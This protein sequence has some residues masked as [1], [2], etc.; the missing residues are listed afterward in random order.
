MNE[1]MYE[2]TNE[3]SNKRTSERTNDQTDKRTNK[4]TNNS[5]ALSPTRG[6]LK[7]RLN[8]DT[9]IHVPL[10]PLSVNAACQLH[11]WAYKETHPLD[12][13]EG[14]NKKPPGSRSHVM[15][16]DT[17]DVHICLSC[18]PIFHQQKHLRRL[19]F[20]ILHEKDKL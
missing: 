5:S 6:R 1:R 16:C 12:K 3:Q 14:A 9:K 18:W 2:Q 19:V 13:M 20:D 8:H 11:R 4:R 10:P 15:R 17:C 7:C